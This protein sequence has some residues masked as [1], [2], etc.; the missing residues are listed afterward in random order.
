MTPTRTNERPPQELPTTM[1]QLEYMPVVIEAHRNDLRALFDPSRPPEQRRSHR[2]RLGMIIVR[3][4]QWVEDQCNEVT[5]EP[6]FLA[7]S[8]QAHP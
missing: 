4:G 8:Q 2:Q 6:P 3:F 7:P 1:I 5:T